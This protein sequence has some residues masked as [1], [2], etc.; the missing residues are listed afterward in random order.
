VSARVRYHAAPQIEK[1]LD[2]CETNAAREPGAAAAVGLAYLWGLNEHQIAATR[3]SSRTAMSLTYPRSRRRREI[4]KAPRVEIP[5]GEVAWMA[6]AV[7]HLADEIKDGHLLF[8]PRNRIQIPIRAERIRA[9]V[10]SAA[11]DATGTNM[12]VATLVSSRVVAAQAEKLP[13][14]LFGTGYAPSYAARLAVARPAL[15]LS[16]QAR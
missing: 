15:I 14:A 8:R 12:T 4:S 7:A 9:L 6:T 11:D 10:E 16:R 13:L 2:W 1:L 3:L 5:V